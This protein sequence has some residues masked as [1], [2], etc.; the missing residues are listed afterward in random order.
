MVAAFLIVPEI[1]LQEVGEEENFKD[2]EHDEQLN[3][4]NQPDLFS[5]PRKVCKP[6]P[7]KPESAFQYIHIWTIKQVD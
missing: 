6:V 7:V 2:D 5:P 4:D 1:G 3:E